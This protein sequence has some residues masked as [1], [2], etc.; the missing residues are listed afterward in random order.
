MCTG[1]ATAS[2]PAS[3]IAPAV[4]SSEARLRA[5]NPVEFESL[6]RGLGAAGWVHAHGDTVSVG[7]VLVDLG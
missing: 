2:P 5:R 1:T 7:D 4:S 3:R 6:L